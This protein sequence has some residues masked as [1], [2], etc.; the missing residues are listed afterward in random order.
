MVTLAPGFTVPIDLPSFITSTWLTDV[1][2][3][4]TTLPEVACT[5]LGLNAPL[6]VVPTMLTVT[7]GVG[8]GAGVVAAGV[9]A[10]GVEV[11]VE[12][13]VGAAEYE[14]PPPPHPI[15]HNAAT[16]KTIARMSM[17]TCSLLDRSRLFL[18]MSP[19]GLDDARGHM[20]KP[21]PVPNER[22][23]LFFEEILKETH[24]GLTRPVIRYRTRKT[25]PVCY[26][27]L[28]FAR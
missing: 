5:G 9:V 25:T 20:A 7:D 27:N 22:N 12:G 28:Y 19:L 8:L 14:P 26:W 10:A 1:L 15:A 18:M 4:H 21:V 3:V 11:D 23:G 24:R 13:E 2:F 16:H 6:P 17:T